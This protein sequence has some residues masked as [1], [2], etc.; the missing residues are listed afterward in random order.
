MVVRRLRSSDDMLV[1]GPLTG[2]GVAAWGEGAELL[3][4]RFSLGAF[5]PALPVPRFLGTETARPS[6]G[7]RF[8]WLDGSAWPLPTHENV[9]IFVARLLARSAIA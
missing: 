9:E 6:A 2:A 3:W 1:V 7:S 8:V 4:V 5:M